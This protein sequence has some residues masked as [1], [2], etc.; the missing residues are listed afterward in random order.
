MSDAEFKENLLKYGGIDA[1]RGNMYLRGNIRMLGNGSDMS[2]L[3]VKDMVVT[4]NAVIPGISFDSLTV[5]G[6]VVSTDGN[7]IGNG[8]LMTGI[9][10][11]LP[12]E[13]NIDIY[14]NVDG[15]YA[16]VRNV[17]AISGNVGNVRMVGGNV[18]A[19]GQ[20]NVRG[21]VV[22][23]GFIGNGALLT[24]IKISGNQTIDIV[25]NVIGDYV[26]VRV[27]TATIGNIGNVVMAG[28]NMSASGQVNVLG[29]V[30]ADYFIG[31]GALIAGTLPTIANTD[32][33]GN[34]IGTYANVSNV[35]AISGNIGNVVMKNGNMS[36]G[37]QVNVLGNVVAG[38]GGLKELS[39]TEGYF[40]GNGALLYDIVAD[41][42][43]VANVDI[44]GNI[45]GTYAS[46]SNVVAISGNIGNVRFE[47]GNMSA[48]G[49]VNVR[50]NVV[51]RG[52]IGNGALLTDIKIS[53]NQTI[54]IVGNVIGDYVN[55]RVITATIGNIGNVVMAGGN[56]SAS[57]QV[58]VLGNVT[59]GY[60]IGNGAFLSD[61]VL[62]KIANVDILGNVIGTYA[63]VSNIVAIFGNIGNVVMEKRN[64]SV[65][66]QVNV[67]GNVV[68]GFLTREGWLDMYFIGNGALL[69]DTA[70]DIPPVAEVDIRGNVDGTYTYA[71]NILGIFGNIGNVILESGNMSASGQVNVRANIVAREFIGNGS[72][73]TDLTV[74]GNQTIDI[75]GNVL[76]EYANVNIVTASSGNIGNVMFSDGNMHM[77]GRMNVPGNVTAGLFIGNGV[78]LT[79]VVPPPIANVDIL[80]NVIGTY[81]NVSNV[82]AISGNIGNVVMENGNMSVSGQVYVLGNVVGNCFI[83]NRAVFSDMK[84]YG[85]ATISANIDVIGNVTAKYFYGNGSLLY[86]VVA[87]HIPPEADIDI[88]GN[89]D[90]AYANVETVEAFVGNIGNVRMLG[91]NVSVS[92]RVI[93]TG[94]VVANCFIG[95]GGLLYDIPEILIP[96]TANVDIHGNVFGTYA[97]VGNITTL[98][99]NIGNVHM[100]N[101]NIDTNGNVVIAGDIVANCFIGNGML[102][103]GIPPPAARPARYLSAQRTRNQT[104]SGYWS[105]QTI[106]M[107]TVLE[108]KG[109]Q[110]DKTAGTFILEKGITYRIVAQLTWQARTGY[111]YPFK[112]I[113]NGTKEQIGILSE[114]FAC[115]LDRAANT[116]GTLLDMI[117]TPSRDIQCCL[118]MAEGTAQGGEQL[119]FDVGTFLNIFEI[120]GGFLTE[121]PSIASAT[122]RGNLTGNSANANN[123]VAIFGNIGN[124]VLQNDNIVTSGQVNIRGNIAATCFIG[125]GELL[126]DVKITGNYPI[127]IKGNVDG[128]YAIVRDIQAIHG[129]VGGTRMENGNVDIR[130]QVNVL[131][132]VVAGYFIGKGIGLANVI[133]AGA[134]TG[135]ISGNVLGDYISV[136]NVTA[137]RFGSFGGIEMENGNV[138]VINRGQIDVVGDVNSTYF[139][140]SGQLLKDVRVF[141]THDIDIRGNVK[142]PNIS[143]VNIN[144]NTGNIGN[145]ILKNDSIEALD[146]SIGGVLFGRVKNLDSL[147]VPGQ[148]N[149]RHHVTADR[150]IGNGALLANLKIKGIQK[151]D[152]QNGNVTGNYISVSNVTATTGNIGNVTM[153]NGNVIA[154]AANINGIVMTGGGMYVNGQVRVLANIVADYFIGNGALLTNV[155]VSGTQNVD[156]R[157]NVVGNY[158][159]VIN[160]TA[161]VGN[162]GNV[163]M[164][165]GNI[166]ANFGNIGNIR[167]E[168]GNITAV[169]GNAGGVSMGGGNLG[170]P[171]HINVF[172][173]IVAS[174]F[175]GDGTEVTG[176]TKPYP[177]ELPILPNIDIVEGNLIGNYINVH[178]VQSIIGNIGNVRMAGG[179]VS[180]SG[181]VNVR[182]NVVANVFIGDIISTFGN[183]GNTLLENG[184]AS[185]SGQVNV[186]GDVAANA[187]FGN[188]IGLYNVGEPAAWLSLGLTTEQSISSGGW[189]D[190]VISI[191]FNINSRSPLTIEQ[192]ITYESSTGKF[193]LTPGLTYRIT[194]QIVFISERDPTQMTDDLVSYGLYNHSLGEFE[195]PIIARPFFLAQKYITNSS[196]CPIIDL[197]VTPR[198]NS[199]KT[200]E[201]YSVRCTSDTTATT[202]E[203]VCAEGT[204]IIVQ[205]VANG[206]L[207]IPK[208]SWNKA[209]LELKGAKLGTPGKREYIWSVSGDIMN[210]KGYYCAPENNT[211]ITGHGEYLLHIPEGYTIHTSITG[212][213]PDGVVEGMPVG[214]LKLCT[215]TAQYTG[216]VLAYDETHMK[217]VI[218]SSN[219]NE[220]FSVGGEGPG[221]ITSIRSLYFTADVPVIPK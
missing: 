150:F 32:I 33:R 66:G 133:L 215:A 164:E 162:I 96:P 169:A 86:D 19:S 77:S 38:R 170:I 57:G 21:N 193:A 4:G 186:R 58:N 190:R 94:N 107:D 1:S 135:D 54:D 156:T 35:V 121:L 89:V 180:T 120:T 197:I 36:A 104:S 63:N 50:G 207:V 166:A 214:Q 152:I 20:V 95:N 88:Q 209:T 93:A 99:G 143:V 211:E 159:S 154:V 113:N 192:A 204:F 124:V 177:P 189:A 84:V 78:L 119:R 17:A 220:W 129:N 64:T 203:R 212:M 106:I 191:G 126:N 103:T 31:N 205:T 102:L 221:N 213:A 185:V 45:I 44:R 23:R 134:Q 75:R 155:I 18:S 167:M 87:T 206:P 174:Y 127:D 218:W 91:G 42:P 98:Y 201:F 30:T 202:D 100:K 56:M 114:A 62:P 6:N 60:F 82:M 11:T 105:G 110:Y 43:P 29:N 187:F 123:L 139:Y 161:I 109:I 136:G 74:T 72:L 181:Q 34:V 24:D 157:G 65:S 151:Y 81:A 47:N 73:L 117:V 115:N 108:G 198:A 15:A 8:A 153:N 208:V 165:T 148:V 140:A 184:N 194:A 179:N 80:G 195:K 175:I 131:C 116:A 67:L 122:I 149:A 85:N 28:G 68:A 92:G 132:N 145:A 138:V 14:G 172:G 3:T 16:N 111:Y 5:A 27:I 146:G 141:G 26:N 46:V 2:Q 83:G 176:V 79:D 53:G 158:I 112:L 51:A 168:K 219:D 178:Y 69:Y 182:G 210:I 125:S 101:G 48:S 183:I 163:K 37:G 147:R 196:P 70:I 41:I 199:N 7:F 59:A 173:N 118:Q 90:G 128:N 188:G 130:G 40:I 52:F 142:G 13:A 216:E 171:G 97:N 76:G 160:V 9:I 49:Q 144:A 39:W 200:K 217:F 137:T 25:G 61:L 12:T 71:E 55:V 22:A 10:S